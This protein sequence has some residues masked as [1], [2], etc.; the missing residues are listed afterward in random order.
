MRHTAWTVLSFLSLCASPALCGPYAGGDGTADNPYLIASVEHL[1]ELG[2]TPSDYESHFL[3]VADLD[4]AG[5]VYRRAVIA[6]DVNRTEWGP[7]GE[8]FGGVFDGG[9]HAISN[10]TA[11]NGMTDYLALF[12]NCG[13]TAVVRNLHLVNADVKGD[14]MASC[15]IARL[16]GL[17]EDCSVTGEVA[18]IYVVGGVVASLEGGL[19][20]NSTCDVT[21]R[22]YEHSRKFNVVGGLVASSIRGVVDGCS[23]RCRIVAKQPLYVGGGLI[24]LNDRG[25]VISSYCEGVD[26]A[27]ENNGQSVGALCGGNGG[28]IRHCLAFDFKVVCQGADVGGLVGGNSSLITTSVA[29]GQVIGLSG[30]GG[31]A[32]SNHGYIIDCYS[33]VTTGA[34]RK[35]GGFTGTN[36]YGILRSYSLGKAVSV[37]DQA[38]GFVGENTGIVDLSFW[39][40]ERSGND[41]DVAA[42]AKRTRELMKKATFKYWG[43]GVWF[44]DENRDYPRLAWENTPGVVIQDDPVEYG[45]GSGTAEDPYLIYDVEHLTRIGVYPQDIERHFRLMADID[46]RG[47]DFHGIG[48]GFGFGGVFDGNG[49]TV[50]NYCVNNDLPF[51]G[52]FTVVLQTGIVKNVVV[53]GFEVS[54]VRAVGGLCGKNEGLIHNCRATGSV[55]TRD[56]D[57]KTS[58]GGLVGYNYGRISECL[59]N[60]TLET[61]SDGM[62]QLGGFV[63]TNSGVIERSASTGHV[64]CDRSHCK[65]IG[66]F[67]GKA[68]FDSRIYDCYSLAA[69]TVSGA[70]CELAGGF[71]GGQWFRTTIQRSYCSADVRLAEDCKDGAAFIGYVDVKETAAHA[72]VVD[73]FWNSD[74]D[75]PAKGIARQSPARIVLSAATTEQLQDAAFLESAHWEVSAVPNDKVWLL[76]AGRLPRIH[77]P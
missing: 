57:A 6:P 28:S 47:V 59:S 30:A 68:W 53:E 5:T 39:N 63:G 15:L 48:F 73:C 25:V 77:L 66:G 75:V 36:S 72:S 8:V 58:W 9:G 67:V 12:G 65:W 16:E 7:Q 11:V 3:L 52:L 76:E 1:I 35:V 26:I 51:S 38:G 27:A 40:A 20:K 29:E 62:S 24:G 4:M 60:V 33:N 41:F 23:A 42:A 44:I 43:D 64:V 46:L 55:Y 50:R 70:D 37:T 49:Y 2:K 19:I 18:G 17:A 22:T 32:G 31:I 45:G 74:H 54:G 21:L 69:V 14:N 71:A 34:V 56:L 61:T 10:F 13:K